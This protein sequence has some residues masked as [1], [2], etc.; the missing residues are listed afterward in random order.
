[1]AKADQSKNFFNFLKTDEDINR[2]L[3]EV[4]DD[5]SRQVLKQVISS[6]FSLDDTREFLDKNL[7]LKES[8]KKMLFKFWKAHGKV[9]MQKIEQPVSNNNQGLKSIDWEINLTTHSRHQSNIQ[10][11]SA[12]VQVEPASTVGARDT[13]ILFEVSKQDINMILDKI[14]SVL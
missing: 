9:I 7:E 13:R 8:Q 10:K 14:D 12:T 5:D 6:N 2:D 4:L 1:M 11:K 3:F